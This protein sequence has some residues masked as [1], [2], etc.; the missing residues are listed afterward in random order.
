M[1]VHISPAPAVRAAADAELIAFL[2]GVIAIRLTGEDTGGALAVTDQLL[3]GGLATP[4]HAQPGDDETFLVLEGAIT[5]V[6][7]GRPL[8]L[9]RGDVGHVPRGV[10]HAFRVETP[11]ARVL[12]LH[13]PA[14]HERF[15]RKAGEATES[16]ELPPAPAG[17][18]D[19]GRMLAAAAAAGVE[20]L[21]PPPQV[22]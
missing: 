3:P 20:M 5:L 17:P 18:P 15:F 22:A 14:G 12:A 13:A 6:A 21:G 4:L 19:M 7:D 1:A 16:T 11:R 8:R 10:A 9:E 2:G